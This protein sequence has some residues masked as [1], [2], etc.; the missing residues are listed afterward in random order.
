M[1][2]KAKINDVLIKLIRSN[3]IKV[4]EDNIPKVQEVILNSYD[5][6]LI[7]KVTNRRS[8]TNPS[9]YLEEFTERLEEFEYIDDSPIFPNL[10]AFIVPDIE[11]FDFSGRLIVIH[12][13]LEGLAGKHMEVSAAQYEAMYGT[14]VVNRAPL[15]KFVPKKERI[16]IFRANDDLLGHAKE[17]PNNLKLVE[18]PFSDTPSIDIFEEADRYVDSEM[19]NWR[20]QAQENAAKELFDRYTGVM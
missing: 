1:F 2:T 7:G 16:Y 15:D 20:D 11:N 14:P 4:M 8:K 5:E 17:L 10:P 12:T 3:L 18:Y 9:L 19:D 13:I 6:N